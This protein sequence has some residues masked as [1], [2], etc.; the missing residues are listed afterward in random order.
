[1]WNVES[2]SQCI[3]DENGRVMTVFIVLIENSRMILLS[4]LKIS[5]EVAHGRNRVARESAE[6]PVNTLFPA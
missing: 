1:M 6:E 5:D 2:G 3:P 4:L